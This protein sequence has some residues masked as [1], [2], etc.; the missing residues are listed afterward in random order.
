[1]NDVN[2]FSGGVAGIPPDLDS[3]F[4]VQFC[5]ET[6]P[7][8]KI[9]M[10][11]QPLPVKFHSGPWGFGPFL[12]NVERPEH[13]SIIGQCMTVWPAVLHQMGVILGVLIGGDSEAAVAIFSTLQN[14]RARRD[15]LNAAAELRLSDRRR[16]LFDAI[17]TVVASA[18]KERNSLAHGC[19]GSSAAIPDGILWIESNKFGTWN[20]GTIL[21]DTQ[22]TSDD[23]KE[24][25]QHI[26]VYKKT[27]LQDIYEQIRETWAITYEFLDYVRY[28]P[29][30]PSPTDE[31]KFIALCGIR[32][33]AA[34][35][36]QIRSGKKDSQ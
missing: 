20:V 30:R 19:F 4:F 11:R 22:I 32:R 1:M 24:L 15:V 9:V 25:A 8:G 2:P 29:P 17:L 10:P 3:L 21:K 7:L 26:Y 18:E 31:S 6:M 28:P 34:A 16:D 23:H 36:A 14:A 13:V 5:F 35:L 12:I 33:V 27:D